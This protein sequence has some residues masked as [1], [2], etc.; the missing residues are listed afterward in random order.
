MDLPLEANSS[1]S[2]S[3]YFADEDELNLQR[4]INASLTHI[5]QVVYD[6]GTTVKRRRMSLNMNVVKKMRRVILKMNKEY[7]LF[8]SIC[9][10]CVNIENKTHS[11]INS[12][13]YPPISFALE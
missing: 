1:Q 13:K 5:E 6:D 11:E 10:T 12:M 9:A 7:D 3:D 2:R 4:A 8:D